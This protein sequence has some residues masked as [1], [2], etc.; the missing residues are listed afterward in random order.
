[1]DRLP[2]ETGLDV[3]FVTVVNR[4]KR[5]FFAKVFNG[6]DELQGPVAEF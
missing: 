6:V 5:D 3:E 1:M 2:A 4:Q